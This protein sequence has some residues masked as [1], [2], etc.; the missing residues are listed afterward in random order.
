[1]GI[2]AFRIENDG[3]LTPIHGA[4]DFAPVITGLAPGTQGIVA[5]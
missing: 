5:T 1:M 2:S 3:N 4:E